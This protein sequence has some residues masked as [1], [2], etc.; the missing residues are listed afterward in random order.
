MPVHFCKRGWRSTI[1]IE[2][3]PRRTVS[4][5]YNQEFIIDSC[6]IRINEA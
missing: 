3:E 4:A 6:D 1:I 2:I 5:N